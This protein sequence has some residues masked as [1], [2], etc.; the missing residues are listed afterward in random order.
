MRKALLTAGLTAGAIAVA[1]PGAGATSHLSCGHRGSA[2]RNIVA[3]ATTCRVAHKVV[4]A[5]LQGKR[6]DGWHCHGKKHGKIVHV[7]CKH[8]GGESVRFQVTG[9]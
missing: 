8:A 4:T 7:T 6:Y 1:T 3:Y 9:V 5:D 2:V